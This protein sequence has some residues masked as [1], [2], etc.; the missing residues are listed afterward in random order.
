MDTQIVILAAGKGKRMGS[1]EVPKVLI[2]LKGKPVILHLLKEV[3]RL[4]DLP[5]PVIVVGYKST[6]VKDTLGK[7]YKYAF[8]RDQGGTAHA[9]WSAQG[10]ITAK[11]I[12]VLYGDIPFIRAASLKKLIHLHQSK[13][14]VI[15]VMTSVVPNYEGKYQHF[16]NLG[17]IVRNQFGEIEKIQEVADADDEQKNIREVNSGIYMFTTEWLWDNIDKIDNKNAQGEFYLTDIVEIAISEG[18][19]VESMTVSPLEIFGIN[20]AVQ[21]EQA[22]KLL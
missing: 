11:N 22:A 9:V 17:R 10:S 21:L 14:P 2:P 7:G 6:A 8:Q 5:P 12:L 15:S 19:P 13:R 4:K 1:K 18:Q 16:F 3:D 20:T